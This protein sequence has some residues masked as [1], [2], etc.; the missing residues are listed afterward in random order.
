[1]ATP[2]FN[3]SVMASATPNSGDPTALGSDGNP[4]QTTV[5]S[6][7]REAPQMRRMRSIATA[8]QI[9]SSGR[10]DLTPAQVRTGAE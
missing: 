10:P 7:G 9:L 8:K 4:V 6:N 2:F 5:L 3:T 1:M